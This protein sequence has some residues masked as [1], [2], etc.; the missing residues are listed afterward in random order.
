M[1][2]NNILDNIYGEQSSQ[3]LDHVRLSGGSTNTIE[4]KKAKTRF[5]DAPEQRMDLNYKSQKVY[6][7]F[8]SHSYSMSGGASKGGDEKI[9]PS[10]EYVNDNEW[11]TFVDEFFLHYLIVNAHKNAIYVIPSSSE[12]KKLIK[13]FHDELKKNNI[14]E[15]SPEA[16]L[17]ASKS[18]L[19]FKSYIFDVYGRSS[20][21]NEKY[22]YQLTSDYPGKDIPNVV[23]RR[24]NRLSVPYFWRFDKNGATVSLCDKFTKSTTLKFVAKCDNDVFLFKGDIPDAESSGNRS[25]LITPALEGGKRRKN[26]RRCFK[27]LLRLNNNDVDAASYEF[28][29]TVGLNESSA[30]VAANK[31][32]SYYSGDFVHTAFSIL[33]D[34]EKFNFFDDNERYGENA[35]NDMHEKIIS[36]YKPCGS[37]P[38]M[39]EAIN[40]VK[41]VYNASKKCANKKEANKLFLSNMKKMYGSYPMSMFKADVATAIIKKNNDV[42]FAFDMMDNMDAI[43]NNEDVSMQL[44]GGATT[45]TNAIYG[46]YSSRPFIGINAKRFAPMLIK[47]RRGGAKRRRAFEDNYDE[48]KN[49]KSEGELFD[50]KL[51]ENAE[52]EG[53]D[54]KKQSNENDDENHVKF[55]A[56]Y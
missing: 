11:K 8:Q 41:T 26:G 38:N 4:H 49:D 1:N 54:C 6:N 27:R 53:D 10:A 22:D 44:T 17:F 32:K 9:H 34:E 18:D 29:G 45:F 16:S 21:D 42:D 13:E 43:E 50:F 19:R 3:S 7:Y 14:E 24:T 33:A 23:L 39:N 40:A 37:S 52:C 36:K 5:I 2:L 51:N 48:M 12:L 25:N 55:S 20:P 47:K 30:D 15:C 56:F 35:I 28:I 46:L 31:L